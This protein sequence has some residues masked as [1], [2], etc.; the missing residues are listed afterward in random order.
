MFPDNPI[1]TKEWSESRRAEL[2]SY[3]TYTNLY[4]HKMYALRY[5]FCEILNLVNVVSKQ[6]NQYSRISIIQIFDYPDS[7]RFYL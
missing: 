7:L 4:T 1:V 2:V 3:L 5:V 6:Q